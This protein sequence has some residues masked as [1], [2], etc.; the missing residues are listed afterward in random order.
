MK[1]K[2]ETN[3]NLSNQVTDRPTLTEERR[4]EMTLRKHKKR[5][6]N[7]EKRRKQEDKKEGKIEMVGG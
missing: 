1:I 7:K 5:E 2:K 4:R 6:G 3:I